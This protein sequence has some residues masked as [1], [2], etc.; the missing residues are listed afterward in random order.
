MKKKLDLSKEQVKKI[1]KS[2]LALKYNVTPQYV[3]QV[4]K[5][6]KVKSKTANSIIQDA[7]QVLDIL[8]DPVLEIEVNDPEIVTA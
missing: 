3:G 5:G 6:K 8:E 7:K 2:A 1:N 4:L